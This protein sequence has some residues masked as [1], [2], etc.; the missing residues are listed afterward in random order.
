M[1]FAHSARTVAAAAATYGGFA[2]C[3][4]HWSVCFV[5][6]KTDGNG[7]SGGVVLRSV[8]R[9]WFLFRLTQG[10]KWKWNVET[11]NGTA[12]RSSGRSPGRGKEL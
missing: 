8:Q 12:S 5:A 2:T 11:P 4:N 7:S 1:F 6:L 9:W 3:P 10:S